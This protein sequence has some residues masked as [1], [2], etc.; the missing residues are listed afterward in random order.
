MNRKR[1]ELAMFVA[2]EAEPTSVGTHRKPP[3]LRRVQI[4]NYKSI[5]FCDVTLEPLTVLV[6]RNG[7]GKSNFLDA[8]G[9]VRDCLQ[10]GFSEAILRHGGNDSI[11]SLAGSGN[12]SATIEL[13]MR[14]RVENIGTID[15]GGHYTWHIEIDLSRNATRRVIREQL[16]PYFELVGDYLRYSIHK[17]NLWIE[18]RDGAVNNAYN[19]ENV[20]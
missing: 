14:N 4:R 18:R 20:S 19:L 6:G 7:S 2:T 5:K 16:T 17:D 11:L 9:F 10:F 3:F 12:F 1:Q 13:Y 8:L 15:G